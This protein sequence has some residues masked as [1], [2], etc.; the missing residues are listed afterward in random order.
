[1]VNLVDRIPC[2]LVGIIHHQPRVGSVDVGAHDFNRGE[3]LIRYIAHSY[4]GISHW[5]LLII[6][7]LFALRPVCS[8]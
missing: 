5:Q 3:K 8:I 4:V 7:L 6:H 2:T 1:M